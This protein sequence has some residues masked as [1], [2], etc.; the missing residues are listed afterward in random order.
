VFDL[1]YCFQCCQTAAHCFGCVGIRKKEYCILNKQYTK[2]EYE[3]LVPRIIEHMKSTR[4]YGEFFPVELSPY[5]YNETTAQEYFPLEKEKVLSRGWKWEEE[6]PFTT[7]K[8]TKTWDQIPENIDDVPED[9]IDDILACEVTKK[10]F[11]ITKQELLFYKK[12]RIPI[13]RLHPDE[14]HRLRMAQRNPRH[15]WDRECGKCGKGMKTTYSP[16]RSEIVYCEECYLK[17]VY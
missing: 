12:F 17:E 7:G 8:E 11:R 14:R 1:T 13:P 5:H 15:L 4:E 3:E 16:E 2:D 10:N 9:I 6:L